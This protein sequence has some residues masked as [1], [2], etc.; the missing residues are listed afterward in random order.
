MLFTDIAGD[1]A[2]C[3][4]GVAVNCIAGMAAVLRGVR[5][6]NLYLAQPKAVRGGILA[7]LAAPLIES[8]RALGIAASNCVKGVF[9]VD[10]DSSTIKT[11]Y[12]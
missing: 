2:V 12:G 7:P 3:G 5:Y 11:I 8:A 4:N 9:W 10:H 1:R 6:I